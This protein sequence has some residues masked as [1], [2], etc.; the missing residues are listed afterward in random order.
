M[1]TGKQAHPFVPLVICS[2]C[3]EY[4]KQPIQ[5]HLDCAV[6]IEPLTDQQINNYL[7]SLGE[8]GASVRA[9]LQDDADLR[10]MAKIPL[11]LN[12]L[13][14]AYH[15]KSSSAIG[16]TLSLEAKQQQVFMTYVQRMLRHRDVSTSYSSEQTIRWLAFLAQQMKQQNQTIFYIEHMQPDWLRDQRSNWVYDFFSIRLAYLLISIP[17]SIPLCLFVLTATYPPESSIVYAV[18]Y[19]LVGGLLGDVFAKRTLGVQRSNRSPFN[20]M[21]HV[22]WGIFLG[23]C[24]GIDMTRLDRTVLYSP[25]GILIPQEA[26]FHN[27]IIYGVIFG[28]SS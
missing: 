17:L 18:L 7:M 1:T 15:G 3:E 28:L 16:A 13:T 6:C 21:R 26:R 10:K 5:L 12:V 14:L 4:F 2:R 9:M 8:Q 19:G 24:I 23:L 25:Y 20:M 11:M 27:G 22:C